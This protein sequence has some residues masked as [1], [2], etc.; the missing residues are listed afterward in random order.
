M[1]APE[2]S[3]SSRFGPLV[4]Q[5]ATVRPLASA[6]L[7]LTVALRRNQR[8]TATVALILSGFAVWGV[9]GRWTIC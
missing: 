6:I 1:R 2:L 9:A 8:D 3:V 7:P 4:T 5:T